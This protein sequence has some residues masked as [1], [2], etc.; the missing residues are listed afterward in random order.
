MPLG[1]GLYF[2]DDTLKCDI[3]EGFYSSA[4]PHLANISYRLG[5]ELKFMGDYEKFADDPEADA[6][7]TREYRKPYIVPEN[8]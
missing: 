2:K 8:V 1:S 7:L 6:F 3:A 5:R 4:L